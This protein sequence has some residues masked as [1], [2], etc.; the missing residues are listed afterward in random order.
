MILAHFIALD[1]GRVLSYVHVGCPY[2]QF[3][4]RR[5]P[6]LHSGGE[7]CCMALMLLEMGEVKDKHKVFL[8]P[9][10]LRLGFCA[11]FST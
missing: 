5:P 10:C 3:L 1:Y 7:G 2:L 4:T 6:G 11:V 9:C 8:L